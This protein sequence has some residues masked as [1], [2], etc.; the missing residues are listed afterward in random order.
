MVA[1]LVIIERSDKKWGWSLWGDNG[2]DVIATDGSQ[3]YENKAEAKQMA[4][5][6]ISGHYAKVPVLERPLKSSQ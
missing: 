3:G 4:F 1:R 2:V 5:K 6:V